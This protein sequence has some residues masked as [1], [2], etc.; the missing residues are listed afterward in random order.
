MIADT[1]VETRPSRSES[2]GR[3]VLQLLEALRPAPSLPPELR[4]LSPALL[5]DIGVD[6][7]LV[8]P[9]PDGLVTPPDLLRSPRALHAFLLSTVR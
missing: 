3:A 9:A 1:Y 5:R 7:R 2:W 8:T 6:P 4:R